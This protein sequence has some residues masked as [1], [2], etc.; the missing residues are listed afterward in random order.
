MTDFLDSEFA[1][2][3]E[4][5]PALLSFSYTLRKV[6]REE[7][8]EGRKAVEER[9]CLHLLLR[10]ELIERMCRPALSAVSALW[11]FQ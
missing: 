3:S 5:G 10:S 2:R 4:R 6:G 8:P 1:K 11:R 7:G 9:A